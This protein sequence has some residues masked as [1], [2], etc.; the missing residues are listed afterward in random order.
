MK[1]VRNLPGMPSFEKEPLKSLWKYWN[2]VRAGTMMPARRD[3]DFVQVAN[4]LPEVS[5]LDAISADELRYTLVGSQI[6]ARNGEE[7]TGV[8]LLD[9]FAD[10]CRPVVSKCLI[11]MFAVP[12]A[13]VCETTVLY[14]SGHTAM[15]ECLCLPLR[16]RHNF[17]GRS[18][19]AQRIEAGDNTADEV[20][21]SLGSKVFSATYI[22][23]G[24]GKPDD[25]EWNAAG[26]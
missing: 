10:D 19:F 16:T 12:C 13:V 1:Q 26:A 2:E 22:D 7:L 15:A 17:L 6:V 24:N 23:I 8:N 21:A 11:D 25:F 20:I 18:L 3:I 9:L 4:V 5:L 14:Q